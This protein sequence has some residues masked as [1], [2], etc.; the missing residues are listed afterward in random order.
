MGELLGQLTWRNQRGKARGL[1]HLVE[2]RLER[3]VSL[4]GFYRS[5]P[6]RPTRS[7]SSSAR[8]P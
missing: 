4:Q 7:R 1:K 3:F 2:G 6:S 5:P 8:D